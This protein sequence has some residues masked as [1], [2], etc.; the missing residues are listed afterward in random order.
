MFLIASSDRSSNFVDINVHAWQWLVLLGLIVALLLVDLLVFHREAHE[1]NTKE[2]AIESAAW[3][4][5]GVAFSLV[6]L[7]WFGGA[8]TGE[9]V[10][11]YLIEKSL[12]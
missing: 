1:I 5:V 4:S 8:A 6:V 11:G 2:A 10:S 7:W 12:S 9:Y 3:I